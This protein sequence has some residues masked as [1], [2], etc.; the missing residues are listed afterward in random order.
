MSSQAPA[1]ATHLGPGEVKA[2]LRDRGVFVHHAAALAHPTGS[3]QMLVFLE[4]YHGYSPCQRARNL[5][6][7]MPGVASADFVRGEDFADDVWWSIVRITLAA[8]DEVEP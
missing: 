2:N 1:A 7:D 5:L 8:E 3:P 6:R 4:G